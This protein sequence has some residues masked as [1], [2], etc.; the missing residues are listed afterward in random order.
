[1]SNPKNAE[2]PMDS[3]IYFLNSD[4]ILTEFLYQKF[5]LFYRSPIESFN[6]GENP[7][8]EEAHL[9]AGE[10]AARHEDLHVGRAARHN[11]KDRVQHM[12]LVKAELRIWRKL[13]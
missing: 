12:H 13:S 5:D 8:E 11:P 4:R 9:H 10:A 3:S 6:P 7:E 1:M 2:F